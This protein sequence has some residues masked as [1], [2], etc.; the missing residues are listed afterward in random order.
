MMRHHPT[1]ICGGRL[2]ATLPNHRGDKELS[3]QLSQKLGHRLQ[4]E[5]GR[6]VAF[7]ESEILQRLRVALLRGLF[8][9]LQSPEHR[10]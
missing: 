8:R 3:V 10:W 2:Q 6:D 5:G 7:L 1:L 4:A 9:P